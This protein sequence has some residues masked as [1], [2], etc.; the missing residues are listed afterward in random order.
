MQ[1]P[2]N[3]YAKGTFYIHNNV[4]CPD[5]H[6]PRPLDPA[7]P[8]QFWMLWQPRSSGLDIIFQTLSGVGIIV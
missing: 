6:F 4:V 3:T 2:Q 1:H 7:G 8:I 5:N